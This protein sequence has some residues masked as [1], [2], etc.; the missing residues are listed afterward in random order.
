MPSREQALDEYLLKN[1]DLHNFV[2]NYSKRVGGNIPPTPL[3][4]DP[5]YA[6]EK[7]DSENPN[8]Q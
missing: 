2:L 4:S 3:K 1:E 5:G 7:N 6:V 8:Y